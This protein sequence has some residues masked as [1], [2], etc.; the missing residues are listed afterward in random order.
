M[1][2]P[3]RMFT[4]TW[5]GFAHGR[6]PCSTTDTNR[7]VPNA[8]SA[9]NRIAQWNTAH[10]APTITA[11]TTARSSADSTSI[12]IIR[13]PARDATPPSARCTA[14][15]APPPTRTPAPAPGRVCASTPPRRS[16]HRVAPTHTCKDTPGPGFPDR[17]WRATAERWPQAIQSPA[18][19]PGQPP[20]ARHSS[21]CSLPPRQHRL[22]GI[23]HARELLRL[24]RRRHLPLHRQELLGSVVAQPPALPR[25][26][27]RVRW[28][29]R[30][31]RRRSRWRWGGR[32]GAIGHRSIHHPRSLRLLGSG[33]DLGLH[34]RRHQPRPRIA[35]RLHR[36]LL[37]PVRVEHPRPRRLPPVVP[38]RLALHP[39]HLIELHLTPVLRHHVPRRPHREQGLAR[40]ELHGVVQLLLAN[41]LA[42]VGEHVAR[43]VNPTLRQ[44]RQFLAGLVADRVDQ[45]LGRDPLQLPQDRLVIQ[46]VH[47][48][49]WVKPLQPFGFRCLHRLAGHR[50]PLRPPRPP[51]GAAAALPAPPVAAQ[52]PA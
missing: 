46:R 34:I 8:A 50:P 26:V 37:I 45:G 18:P 17:S 5:V 52:C 1:P 39:E 33:D 25:R 32:S 14:C 19:P 41:H 11:H 48:T 44:P 20:A 38:Q 7:L 22:D 31:R 40:L 51:P 28:L 43:L 29:G 12:P 10:T 47:K 9:P 36:P 49:K 35:R 24:P 15:L 13:P 23:Q 3:V 42:L 16:P 2:D 21:S 30:G 4:P 6:G 27:R